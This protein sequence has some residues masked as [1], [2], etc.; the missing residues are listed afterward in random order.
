MAILSSTVKKTSIQKLKR[1][2]VLTTYQFASVS[3]LSY[4]ATKAKGA[5]EEEVRS[6]SPTTRGP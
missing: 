1:P 6:C 3:F 5:V 2:L 4:V